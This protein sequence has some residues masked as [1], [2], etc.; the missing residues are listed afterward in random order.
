MISEKVTFH[1]II[2]LIQQSRLL[3]NFCL[4]AM[5]THLSIAV[6]AN[7]NLQL[8]HFHHK[9]LRPFMIESWLALTVA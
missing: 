5:G 1:G 3:H 2:S 8:Y 9:A 7:Q 6:L 4:V